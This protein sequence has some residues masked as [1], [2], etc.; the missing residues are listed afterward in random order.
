MIL[1]FRTAFFNAAQSFSLAFRTKPCRRAK[2]FLEEFARTA[3]AACCQKERAF[4]PP[5]PREDSLHC[6]LMFFSDCNTPGLLLEALHMMPQKDCC[7][8]TLIAC[9]LQRRQHIVLNRPTPERTET[10]VGHVQELLGQNILGF[11]ATVLSHHIQQTVRGI[12]ELVAYTPLQCSQS[13]QQ[14]ARHVLEHVIGSSCLRPKHGRH[15]QNSKL[16]WSFQSFPDV[17]HNPQAT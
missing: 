9:S 7:I 15:V 1:R 4:R 17:I 11:L 5:P 2:W 14:L 8:N 10:T 16:Q 3:C 13:S 12:L 6:M